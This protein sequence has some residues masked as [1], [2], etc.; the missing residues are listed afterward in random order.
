MNRSYVVNRLLAIGYVVNREVGSYSLFT[1]FSPSFA[2]G[3]VFPAQ[4]SLV[5]SIVVQQPSHYAVTGPLLLR[6]VLLPNNVHRQHRLQQSVLWGIVARSPDPV[7]PRPA[8]M[9]KLRV[10]SSRKV[11]GQNNVL[12]QHRLQQSVPNLCCS[13]PFP[14][15]LLL[16]RVLL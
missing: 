9:L 1:S 2:W 11:Q 12:R 5:N 6:P 16:L 13:W 10:A 14:S 8:I 3:I 7:Q 4:P 15:I